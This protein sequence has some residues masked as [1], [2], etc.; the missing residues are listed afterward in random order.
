MSETGQLIAVG[1]LSGGN[2]IVIGAYLGY[3]LLTDVPS[4]TGGTYVFG[5]AYRP[6][7]VEVQAVQVGI[8]RREIWKKR[9]I[10]LVAYRELLDYPWR[11]RWKKE[12][13]LGVN[14]RRA[15]TSIAEAAGRDLRLQP[16]EAV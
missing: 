5:L 1:V 13:Q 14:L 6:V 12:V 15:I 3:D 11:E 8:C 4:W 10:V 9:Q 16:C 7:F 2:P